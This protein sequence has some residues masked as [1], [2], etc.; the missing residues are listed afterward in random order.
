MVSEER[1]FDDRVNAFQERFEKFLKN[2]NELI[3]YCNTK[4]NM[5]VILMHNEP[6][7]RYPITMWVE[8]QQ[9]DPAYNELSCVNHQLA[10]LVLKLAINRTL[11]SP[12]LIFD[13]LDYVIEPGMIK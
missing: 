10:A 1:Q 3:A 12:I 6:A 4:W 11:D 8:D 2:M 5:S 13:S 9:L 7:L